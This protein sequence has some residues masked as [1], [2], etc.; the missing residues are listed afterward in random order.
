MTK[1][2][3]R[4]EETGSNVEVLPAAQ[5]A[6]SA[7]TEA[8]ALIGLIER[9]AADPNIDI[10]RVE[11]MYAMY[12]RAAARNSKAAYI[13]A[14]SAMQ[15]QL[16]IV[17]KRGSINANEKDAAGKPT[18]RQVAMTKYAKWEDVVEAIRPVMA[19]HGFSISFR[20]S[21][22]TPERIQ[23][24]GVLGHRDGHSEETSMSLPLDS[25]GAKNNVQGWGSSVSYGKRYTAF[26]LLNIV[27]RDEDNDGAGKGLDF[28]TEEQEAE[29]RDLIEAKQAEIPKFCA[30]FKIEKL[31][32]LKSSDFQR[33]MTA[34]K[35]RGANG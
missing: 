6:P 22:P 33:A 1:A 10:E 35:K 25:S 30:Y 13:S 3:A 4:K 18:G 17:G 7:A 34:L 12:E 26:A 23:V 28:I 24:T 14:L 27:A 29:L 8:A 5:P 15:P 21:Q 32:D 11:R 2:V 16:P 20:V 19:T 9:A 31:G